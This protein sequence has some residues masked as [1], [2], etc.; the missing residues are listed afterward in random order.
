MDPEGVRF[1]ASGNVLGVNNPRSAWSMH[2]GPKLQKAPLAPAP[3]SS[4][5]LSQLGRAPA[6]KV[7]IAF[8][9]PVSR[10]SIVSSGRGCQ[11]ADNR[12]YIRVPHRQRH[13]W[14]PEP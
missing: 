6:K 11:P 8:C 4:T 1:A 7:L 2:F 14:L 13:S 3:P 5:T 9:V 10:L 12:E